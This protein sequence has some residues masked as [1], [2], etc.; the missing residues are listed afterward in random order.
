M[1]AFADQLE[2]GAVVQDF[3]I[4]IV[5]AGAAGIAMAQRLANTSVKVLLLVSGGPADRGLPDN[6]R[7]TLYQGTTGD[8]LQRVDPDFLRRSRLNMYGGTTNH[9][10]FWARPLDPA[11][12]MPRPGYRDAGWPFDEREL[13]PW[14]IDAHEFGRFGPFNYDDMEFW[15]RILYARC[16]DPL[17]GDKLSGA[18][19]RAQYE[20]NLHD[21]QV[22]F[23][24]ALKSAPNITVLFNAHLL[25]IETDANRRRVIGLNCSTIESSPAG[26]G[27]AGVPF[28]AR[29]RRY[30]L[31]CGGIENVRLLQLSGDLGNNR[32]DQLGRGFMVHPLLTNAARVRFDA[33]VASD[34]RNFF[35]EQQIRLKPPESAGGEYQHMVRP[36]VNPELVFDYLMFNAWGVLAARHE[37]LLEERIGNFRVIL[38]FGADAAS[39]IVNLNWEQTPD[40]DSRI[41]LNPQQVDPIF[42][43]P[44]AH[45]DWRLN[46]TDKRSAARALEI[47]LDYLRARGARQQE[48]ITD[49]SGGAADWT[50]PP[51]EGAL[52]TGDHH[53]GALRMSATPEDGIVNSNSR[54]HSVDNLYIAG[55]AVFPTGGYANPTLTIVALALRLADHLRAESAV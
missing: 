28:K 50:F 45:V 2:A 1:Y 22:Q 39:A 38:Y 21:F 12:Y 25:S 16:F 55:S 14:Y 30:V 18:I 23:R 35:R 13:R 54:L 11:D 32:R 47:T 19:M 42:G 10:G 34:I 52:E 53:I 48:M 26:G 37:T 36:L 7:Q 31:A 33:P 43:Q 44:V 24:E 6:A 9:F 17:P 29:A 15:E 4:C 46:E 40:E 51:D 8:F 41:S 3:D 20:E 27:R 49:V 5:G